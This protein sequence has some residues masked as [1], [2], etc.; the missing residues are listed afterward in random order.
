MAKFDPDFSIFGTLAGDIT[1]GTLVEKT[2]VNYV[3]QACLDLYGDLREQEVAS[4]FREISGD[5]K[6]AGLLVNRFIE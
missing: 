4:I 5:D 1:E 6:K 3:N 2:R